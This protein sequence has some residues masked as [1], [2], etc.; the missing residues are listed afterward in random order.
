LIL[1]LFAILAAIAAAVAIADRPGRRRAVAM[2]VAAVLAPTLIFADQW[3]TVEIA[4]LRSSPALLALVLASIAVI[5]AAGA[6]LIHRWPAALA[7]LVVLTL[8]F[9]IP[10]G[11]GG[12]GANLLLPLYLAMAAGVLAI[13]W[14]EFAPGDGAPGFGRRGREPATGRLTR[15]FRPLLA[16]AVVVYAFGLTWS[17]DRSAGLLHL[18]FFL[19]PFA[20]V[21]ALVTEIEWTRPRLSLI[22]RV[23]L[24]MALLCAVIGLVEWQSHTLLWNRVVIRSNDFHVYFRVNSLF[25]DPN[26]FGRY[27]ALAITIAAAA[28]S[29]LRDR[30]SVVALVCVTAVLWTALL[31]TYSQ[32]SFLALLAGLAVLAALRWN[33]R[34]VVAGLAAGAAAVLVLAVVAGGLVKLDPG[35]LNK[36][37]SGRANLVEGGVE[38]FGKR[39]VFGYGSGAFAT[40]FKHEVAG[41]GA[42]V[43]ESHTEPVTIAAERGLIGLAFYVALLVAALAV[44]TAGFRQVMPGLGAG[45]S[46][47]DPA[48]GPPVARAAIFAAFVAVLVHTLTYAGFLGDPVTWVLLAIGYSLAFPCRDTSAD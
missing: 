41:S 17:G 6:A 20:I 32:S 8:P 46:D 14:R 2:G 33:V 38:L 15:W 28:L 29:W 3:H 23:V 1:S 12:A 5:S 16:A 47:S 18:C 4:E 27:L 43:S 30:R 26:V 42:R 25:W 37:T 44:L 34:R 7:V 39:P 9:R 35:A 36:Q 10:I 22:T 21:F 40:A 11:V 19:I 13:L 24:G 31:A 45:F 48:R